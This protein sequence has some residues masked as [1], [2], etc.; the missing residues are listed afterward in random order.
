[1][2]SEERKSFEEL[3]AEALKLTPEERERLAMTLLSSMESRLEFEAEWIEEIERRAREID[4]GLVET[5]PGDEV[6]R[7]ALDRLK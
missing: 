2:A 6:I 3:L 5:I 7:E 4:E 1:M